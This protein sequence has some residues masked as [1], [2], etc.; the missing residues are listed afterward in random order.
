MS[1]PET[2]TLLYGIGAQ[3]AGTTWVHALLAQSPEVHL[4][5][6]KELHYFDTETGLNPLSYTIRLKVLAQ[7]QAALAREAPQPRPETLARLRHITALLSI[8]GGDARGRHAPYLDY[9]ARGYA[10]QKVVADLT[11]AYAILAPATFAEMAAL[12]P[13]TRFLFI[14]RDPVA[15]MWSQIRMAAGADLARDAPSDAPPAALARAARARAEA[16]IGAGR[17]PRVER[18]DYARTLAALDATVPPEH[19]LCLFYE[20]LFAP[21]TGAGCAA[22]LAAFLG[23]GPLAPGPRKRVNAGQPLP[24]PADLEAAFRTAFAPQYAAIR[25]R[26]GDAVPAAW[27]R[28]LARAA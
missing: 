11:P 14:L 9:L 28:R 12:V 20:D 16:L 6:V 3:K 10:G 22:R 27:G 7:V 23:L 15:R 18:A 24:L 13:R 19:L 2:A 1:F 21:E 5:P 8:H 4:P 25:A 26:F 17:L